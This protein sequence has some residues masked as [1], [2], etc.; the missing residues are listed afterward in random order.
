MT[1]VRASN[2]ADLLGLVEPNHR[3]I[4]N[5]FRHRFLALALEAYRRE[6]IARSKLGELA[7]MVDLA[8]DDLDRLIDDSAL[9]GDTKVGAHQS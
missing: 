4:R 8:T 2:S 5:E 3:D 9:G 6:E 7:S 1:P